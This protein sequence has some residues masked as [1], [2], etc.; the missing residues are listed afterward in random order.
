[1]KEFKWGEWE[2][3]LGNSEGSIK[4]GLR[5]GVENGNMETSLALMKHNESLNQD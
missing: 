5:K 3:K 1:M 2:L 4:N